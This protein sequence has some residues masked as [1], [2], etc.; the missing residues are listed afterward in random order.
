M[1]LHAH[2]A[3]F[4]F[5]HTSGPPSRWTVRR[6][7][8]RAGHIPDQAA[9]DALHHAHL[10]SERVLEGKH[11]AKH[12]HM[13]PRALHADAFYAGPP[14]GRNLPRRA[15]L[16]VVA[17]VDAVVG[18]HGGGRAPRCPRARLAAECRC[19]YVQ[20]H[21]KTCSCD[22]FLIAIHRPPSCS[23]RSAYRRHNRLSL[24]V[25]YAYRPVGIRSASVASHSPRTGER[26]TWWDRPSSMVETT[27]L[28]LYF[29][30]VSLWQT[31]TQSLC[32]GAESVTA[33]LRPLRTHAGLDLLERTRFFM[34]QRGYELV[35]QAAR[36]LRSPNRLVPRRPTTEVKPSRAEPSR[37]SSSAVAHLRER[38]T[39]VRQLLLL[40]LPLAP[41]RHDMV[42]QAR[43]F[44]QR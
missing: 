42:A 37:A 15:Q 39:S 10:A 30:H 17:R 2:S 23:H 33:S 22:P 38:F 7:H 43:P 11:D 35:D 27:S 4:L 18:L 1:L 6:E 26:H 25:S 12:C 9:V 19:W 20:R 8:Q 41:D 16:P 13:R 34:A 32:T 24:H 29:V 3:S 44:V 21:W 31:S 40:L 28:Y 36:R 14:D 5:L